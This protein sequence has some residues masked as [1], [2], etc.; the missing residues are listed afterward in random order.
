MVP[1][2]MLSVGCAPSR[3][4]ATS[5]S[6]TN[7]GETIFSAFL[8]CPARAGHRAAKSNAKNEKTRTRLEI[9]INALTSPRARVLLFPD[10]SHLGP[11]ERH[12]ALR[13]STVRRRARRRP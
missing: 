7:W 4:S 2:K 11:G 10:E 1:S 8:A 13:S 9:L 12:P 3:S 5:V 6:A